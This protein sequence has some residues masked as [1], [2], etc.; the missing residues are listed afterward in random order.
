VVRGKTAVRFTTVV[1]GCFLQMIGCQRHSEKHVME[2][3]R[4]SVRFEL[5]S[6]SVTVDAD[7]LD[8]MKLAMLSFLDGPS[9]PPQFLELRESIRAELRSSAV[10]IQAGQAGIGAW[11]LENEAGRLTL[12]RYP[13]PTTGR[14]YI[15]HA[16]LERDDSGWKVLSLEQEREF[17]P[18]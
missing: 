9:F 14:A 15:Y 2:S 1:A 18:A 16:P 7:T 8:Q 13:P 6:G 3:R 10:W 17:G 4:D 5:K 11:R 12:V